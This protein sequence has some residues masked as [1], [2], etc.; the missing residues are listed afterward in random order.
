MLLVELTENY[1]GVRISG[2]YYDLDK[3]YDAINKTIINKNITE[4]ME[5]MQYHLYNFLYEV[6]HAYQGDRSFN[7]I[8]NNLD[9]Y[10][11]KEN[12]IKKSEVANNNLYF[13]FDYVITDILT[14]IMLI[15]YFANMSDNLNL[16]DENLNLIGLFYS[17]VIN[18]IGS[19]LSKK[20]FNEL[21][22]LISKSTIYEQIYLPQWFTMI[23]IDYMNST[24]TKRKKEF[25]EIARRIY[26]YDLYE[27][28]DE[29]NLEVEKMCRQKNCFIKD[30]GINEYPDHIEW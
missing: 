15:K 23:S 7:F 4:R 1:T 30:I 21:K 10:N 2:D 14:D 24:K 5:L 3:L 9:D 8:A 13:S 12:G 25:L 6:R 22:L 17:K 29:L 16:F 18:A 28:F 27:D 26:E 11:R 19:I 20:D